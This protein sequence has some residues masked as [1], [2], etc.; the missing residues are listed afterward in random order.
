[1]PV[2]LKFTKENKY[3]LQVTNNFTGEKCIIQI[4]AF[5]ENT[6][7]LIMHD[8][9]QYYRFDRV[10]MDADCKEAY[11]ISEETKIKAREVISQLEERRLEL[12]LEI[13]EK[14][15]AGYTPR[16]LSTQIGTLTRKINRLKERIGELSNV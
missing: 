5:D 9:P 13:K 14:Y 6:V 2:S 10:Y 1:M 16:H 11:K 7:Q 12:R 15:P 8:T 4:G 3:S